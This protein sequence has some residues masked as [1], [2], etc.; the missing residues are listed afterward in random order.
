ML[1]IDAVVS[2]NIT[3][4][5]LRRALGD[6]L[7]SASQ[8]HD[9]K[10]GQPD[11]GP[12]EVSIY[13]FISKVWAKERSTHIATLDWCEWNGRPDIDINQR[14]LDSCRK[15]TTRFSLDDSQRQNVFRLV[16]TAAVKAASEG[17]KAYPNDE[18]KSLEVTEA[19]L[20]ADCGRICRRYKISQEQLDE[21]LVEGMESHWPSMPQD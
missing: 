3:E 5:S 8:D 10:H 12:T 4:Q 18:K 13:L 19:L 2:G 16:Y 11:R 7:Q 21:I 9:W 14:Q 1:M 20:L 15:P 17:E 6:L